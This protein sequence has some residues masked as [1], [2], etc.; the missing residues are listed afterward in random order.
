MLPARVRLPSMRFRIGPSVRTSTL[1][2]QVCGSFDYSFVLL[3]CTAAL[4]MLILYS[5]GD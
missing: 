4:D 2:R 1:C 5:R 3:I